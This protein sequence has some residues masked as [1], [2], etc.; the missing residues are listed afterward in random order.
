VDAVKGPVADFWSEQTGG[1]VRIGVTHSSGWTPTVADCSDATKLWNEVAA[2]VRFTPGPG[3]HLLLYI[4][5]AARDCS[6]ALAEVGATPASGG[7]LYVTDLQPSAMAHELGHNFGLGHS[8][9]LQCDGA[10]ES[11]SCRT[12]TYRDY[13]DVMGASWARMGSLNAPQAAALG[14]LPAGQ[15][16][17]LVAGGSPTTVTLAP[18]SGRSGTRAVR[19]TDAAGAQYWLE[20]RTPTARDGWLGTSDNAYKLE[21]G[22]LLRR[23]GAMPDTSVLLDGTPGPAT[24][25][26]KD[27]QAALPVG[28]AVPVSGGQFSVVVDGV[29]A[30][31]AVVTVTPAPRTAAVAPAGRPAAVVPPSVLPGA[32]S[33]GAGGEAAPAA[34]QA[35]QFWAPPYAPARQARAT[36]A[37]APAANTS[38]LGLLVPVGGALIAGATL[39]LVRRN[40]WLRRLVGRTSNL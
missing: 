9:G 17:L 18:L 29:S 37:L 32:P 8:S 7:R 2:T 31:G 35:D 33:S 10:L 15:Q 39:L 1:A 21:T 4:S 27:F 36:P 23:G 38:G 6:Y 30:D 12:A 14:A 28:A 13:Y 34:A 16:Q 5:S 40:G 22:V 20:Y 11:G 26:A 24:G 25:W 3:E 19:L